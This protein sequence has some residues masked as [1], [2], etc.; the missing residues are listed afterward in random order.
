MGLQT[1]LPIEILDYVQTHE[2]A[3]DAA[4]GI[5]QRE[6][7]KALGYH[8][9]S[10]SRP[11]DQLVEEGLLNSRRGLVPDGRRKQLVYR[12]TPDGRTRLKRETREV[13]ILS[14]ELPRPPIPS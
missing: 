7:A 9:C 13:P 10:M 1:Y 8:P 11:L 6:L 14:G 4:Y 2:P 5:S 12:L 3:E